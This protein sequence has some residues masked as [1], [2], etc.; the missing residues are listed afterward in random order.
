[1]VLV[2]CDSTI[3]NCTSWW[4]SYTHRMKYDRCGQYRSCQ[5]STEPSPLLWS[6]S[7]AWKCPPS[8]SWTLWCQS[9]HLPRPPLPPF[10]PLLHVPRRNGRT[11]YFHKYIF[12]E[13]DLAVIVNVD[14]FEMPVE[15]VL[16]NIFLFDPQVIGK[17][18]SELRRLEGWVLILVVGFENGLESFIDEL[19]DI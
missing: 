10:L 19:F 14:A 6:G 2:W 18:H 8:I 9:G 12:I 15:L 11:T 13:G 17:E 4:M 5:S 7:R 1:M 3:K 16:G